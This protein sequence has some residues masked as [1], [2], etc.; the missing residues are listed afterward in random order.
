MPG[1]RLGRGLLILPP[2]ALVLLVLIGP[3]VLIGLFSVNSLSEFAHAPTGFSTANWHDFL[4][5]TSHHPFIGDDNSFWKTFERSMV[6]TLIVSA[7]AVVAAYPLAFF[8]AFIARK[9]RFTLLFVILAPFFT[10]YLLRVI[11][12]QIMLNS[13]G[14][15]TWTLWH[16]HIIPYGHGVSWLLY[17]N[18]SVGLVLFYTWVP[19]VC[20]PIFVVLDNL[21]A[22]LFE[23]A[24]DT[25]ANPIST[26]LH[27]T[28]PLSLPGVAAGFVFV[29]IPTTGEFI[30]P[31][32]VGG[33]SSYMFGNTIQAFFTDTFN[34]NYGSVLALWLV[35]VVVVMLAIF[36]RFLNSDLRSENA[37]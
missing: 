15:V 1:M 33:P 7:S 22:H 29:L 30:T 23:A 37:R 24:A 19:F 8:L 11:A 13:H 10:S 31:L 36:G 9:Q 35:G 12:W 34:W 18:F 20:L 21:D 6:I 26:F 16:L 27:V 17:S 2:S 14:P 28:L 4:Y 25:G 32:L 3:L 5:G